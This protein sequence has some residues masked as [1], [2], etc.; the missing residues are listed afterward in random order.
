[1]AWDATDWTIDRATGDIRYV[2]DDHGGASPTYVTVID[3]HR[4]LQ[5]LADDAE[6]TGDDE[7]AIYDTDPSQ[8][9]TDN[10]VRLLGNYN[11]TDA[12]AEHIYDGSIIQGSGDTE[13]IYDGVVNYGN[14]DV[15]IQIHQNGAVLADDWWNQGGAGLNADA[16]QGIS[17]RFMVKV[18]ENGVDINGRQL[19]GTARRFNKTYSEFRINSTARGNNVLALTDTDDLNNQTAAG[20]VAGWTGI[21]NT[22]EGYVGIDVNNDASDEFYY[23]EWNANTPT[24]SIND[25]YERLKWLTRDGSASTLYGIN[26]ELF[27]GITHEIV[28]DGATNGGPVELNYLAWGTTFNYNNEQ[29]AGLTVGEFYIFG[30]SG[31]RGQLLALDDDGTTGFAV[32]AIQPGSGTVVNTETFTRAD[33]TANDGADVNSVPVGTSDVG[34]WGLV[35]ADNASD[36]VWIQLLKGSAPTNNMVMYEA[37]SAGVHDTATDGTATVNVT[38]TSRTVPTPFVGAS[39]GSAII[40]GYGLGIQTDDLT[41]N[42]TLFDLTNSSVNPPNNVTFSVNGLVASEDQILVAPWDGS[43]LD[44]NGDPAIDFDQFSLNTTL[45]GASE[46]AVDVGV[47]IPGDTPSTGFIRVQLDDGNYRQQ[48]YTGWSGTSFTIAST[49]YSGGNVATAG[50]NVFIGYIDKLAAAATESFTGVYQSDRD[51]V[52]VV[53]DGKATPIKQ[54]IGQGLLGN[55]GGS[56]NAIRTSDT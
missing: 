24:R 54:F 39:T 14:P 7:I 21:T 36:R 28:Y 9:S 50:N 31:A 41:Q 18:K 47:A 22:N 43:T 56:V 42:D 4:E 33:G 12:E 29:A 1:M 5:A 23:S 49:D 55:T 52:V 44:V 25:F 32:F 15:Q 10:I 20:T 46:T 16:T 2:G 17:H 35:L 51:L 19:L 27:R 8:R 53:R 11:I 30:T 13:T 34:G 45:S 26:G 38:V 40:G 37:T 48:A 3:F 6:S